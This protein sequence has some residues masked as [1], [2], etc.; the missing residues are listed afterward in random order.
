MPRM[1]ERGEYEIHI[2][3]KCAKRINIEIDDRSPLIVER[4]YRC[5]ECGD[6]LCETCGNSHNCIAEKIN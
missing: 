6:K 3:N 2:C 5:M 4:I 1:N